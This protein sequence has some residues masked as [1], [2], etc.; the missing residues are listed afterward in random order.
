M[1][2]LV[3]SASLTRYS[4]IARALGIDPVRMVRQAGLDQSCLHAPDLRVP[5]SS[6]AQILE[7]SARSVQAQAMGLLVAESWR[8]SDFG[9]ISLLLQHQPTLRHALSE[10]M[11]YRHLLSDSVAVDV[12]DFSEIAVVQ[13]ALDTG[14]P[15][16]GRQ[17]AE[18]AV[19]AALSLLRTTLGR[20]WLPRSVH[21]A[22]SAPVSLQVHRRMFG[23]KVDFDCEFDGIVLSQQDLDRANP[24]ADANMARYAR[25]FLD[26]QPRTRRDSTADEVRRALR[27]LLPR[28]GHAIDQVGQH[29]GMSSRSLQRQLE[30]LGQSFSSLLNEVRNDL[31][32]R[33]LGN[34]AYPVSQVAGLLGFSEVSAFSRWFSTQFGMPPTQWRR[35][36]LDRPPG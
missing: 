20:Q 30:Q 19:G 7:V 27:S 28:G 9:A 4:E 13:V 6:L 26:L 23:A 2:T 15:D 32:V 36:A 22:H 17:A 34:P 31:A 8:L 21:F 12:E 18:L 10:L 5:E 35:Q 11:H 1:T 25:E 3:R 16:A 14:R 33:Y 24:R 29:L